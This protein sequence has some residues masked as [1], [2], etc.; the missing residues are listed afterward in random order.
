MDILHVQFIDFKFKKT[1]MD[2]FGQRCLTNVSFFKTQ[3]VPKLTAPTR[4][5]MFVLQF[6][7]NSIYFIEFD[8][9]FWSIIVATIKINANIL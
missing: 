6:F 2:I 5:A 8:I 4:A 9:R 3:S 1:V 7:T